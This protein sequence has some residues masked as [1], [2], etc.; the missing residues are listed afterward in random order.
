MIELGMII[1]PVIRAAAFTANEAEAN[2]LCLETQGAW[3]AGQ[4]F[5]HSSIVQL[6]GATTRERDSEEEIDAAVKQLETR[7]AMVAIKKTIS[8]MTREECTALVRA[9]D[10]FDLGTRINALGEELQSVQI[11]HIWN[12]QHP[13]EAPILPTPG[14]A[15]EI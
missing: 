5:A 3:D 7:L 4:S 12:E 8:Q 13:N 9:M 6:F 11:R 15:P 10:H 1:S 2:Q 14:L